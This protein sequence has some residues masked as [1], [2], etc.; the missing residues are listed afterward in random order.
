MFKHIC[1]V[2]EVGD[3]VEQKDTKVCIVYVP[4][5]NILAGL[6]CI[7]VLSLEVAMAL[8]WLL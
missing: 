1:P 2:P 6:Y 8:S 5:G 7:A 3:V 4:A